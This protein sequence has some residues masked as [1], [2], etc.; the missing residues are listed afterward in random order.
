MQGTAGNANRVYFKNGAAGGFTVT[1]SGSSDADTG[2]AS[3]TYPALTGFT[4]TGVYTFTGASTTRRR[5]SRPPTMPASRAPATA[6]PPSRRQRP[7]RRRLQRQR[8]A[9][10][11][12]GTT[13]YVTSG[14]TLTINSRTDYSEAQ[15]STESGLS[16]STLTIQSATLNNNSCGSYG[17][18]TT[19][20][21]TTSQTVASGNCYLLTL[22]GTDSR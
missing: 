1:A 13:S 11:A 9:A 5:R 10:T 4:G 12:G 7:D 2:V 15:S 17:G 3:Y 21:G 19:I 8:H 18:T 16:T 14:T 22:T 6:S 20:T